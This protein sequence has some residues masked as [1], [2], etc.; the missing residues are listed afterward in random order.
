[1]QDAMDSHDNVAAAAKAHTKAMKAFGAATPGNLSDAASEAD[2]THTAMTT[3]LKTH[4]KCMKA[5]N[6]L[7]PGAADS[8]DTQSTPDGEGS[9]GET[10]EKAAPLD[11]LLTKAQRQRKAKALA[12][13]AA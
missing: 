13:S 12:L 11:K 5:L 2:A 10:T 7:V 4:T 1:M 8:E 3:A 9:E 6:E